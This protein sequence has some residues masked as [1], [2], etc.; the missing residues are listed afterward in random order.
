MENSNVLIRSINDNDPIQVTFVNEA[1]LPLELIW[2]DYNGNQVSY[3][4]IG[5]AEKMVVN[6]FKTHP[7]VAKISGQQVLING[8][9]IFDG[10][11]SGEQAYIYIPNP[12]DYSPYCHSINSNIPTVLTFKNNFSHAVDIQ[13]LNYQGVATRY[14]NLNPGDSWT[15]DTY[16]THPW[17]AT[18]PTGFRIPIDHST[19]YFPTTVSKTVE[20]AENPI[21]VFNITRDMILVVAKSYGLQ[22]TNEDVDALLASLPKITTAEIDTEIKKRSVQD[23]SFSNWTIGMVVGAILGGIGGALVTVNPAG[24]AAGAFLG[25]SLGAQIGNAATLNTISTDPTNTINIS[26]PSINR[27]FFSITPAGGPYVNQKVWEDIFRFTHFEQIGSSGLPDAGV[28][29]PPSADGSAQVWFPAKMAVN[30]YIIDTVKYSGISSPLGLLSMAIFVVV[31]VQG[32]SG[33]YQLR[34]YPDDV[35]INSG[36]RPNHSQLTQGSR[37]LS[38]IGDESMYVY[39]A[40]EIYCNQ[41]RKIVGVYPKTGHYF[42]KTPNFNNEVIQT[43]M[44]SLKALGYDTTNIKTGDG[45][46]SWLRGYP[47]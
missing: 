1:Q 8:E 20:I 21:D 47:S 27:T 26:N 32:K 11:S 17:I 4:N 10:T 16:V 46:I 6:T 14:T 44:A 13:W 24:I 18:T 39:A 22:M 12:N 41:N 25:A 2:F 36:T 23:L 33:S 43:A 7:W 31:D 3:G 35:L 42:N 9:E 37:L 29:Y 30:P 15:V 38:I 34:L 5:S 28:L 45:F 19:V 40:G